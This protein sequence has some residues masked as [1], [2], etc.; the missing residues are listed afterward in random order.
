MTVINNGLIELGASLHPGKW[1]GL[2]IYIEDIARSGGR[3]VTARPIL[4]SDEQNVIDVGLKQASYSVSGVITA[5]YLT[6]LISTTYTE[7]RD[8]FIAAC[9][10][11]SPGEL[12][13]PW[14]GII[15]NLVVQ[16]DAGCHL[17]RRGLPC[18]GR[19]LDIGQQEGDNARW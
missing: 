14:E 15:E 10:D 18:L 6:L 9:E 2:Q 19:P 13:S 11:G 5:K 7:L 1:R 12:Q 16:R 8:D 17:K 3:K 4:N